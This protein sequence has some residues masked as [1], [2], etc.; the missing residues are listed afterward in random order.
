MDRACRKPRHRPR[1]GAEVGWEAVADSRSWAA[2][3]WEVRATEVV[4]VLPA[5]QSTPPRASREP[6]D[7]LR[8]SPAR[9]S[10]G[11]GGGR[12]VW[13]APAWG[14]VASN[15]HSNHAVARLGEVRV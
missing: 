11:W 8:F 10:P 12:H 2:R 15:L 4:G 13:L 3:P 7:R 9:V 14:Y 6:S 1:P 5:P